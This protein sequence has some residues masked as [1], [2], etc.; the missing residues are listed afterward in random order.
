M[1]RLQRG[2][3][4]VEML[5]AIAVAGLLVSLVYGAIRVGQ[6]SVSAVDSRVQQSELMRIGWQFIHHAIAHAGPAVD[7]ARPE[8]R[9]GFEGTSDQLVFVADMPSY[10]GIEGPARITL[11]RFAKA[12]AA[13][14]LLTRGR[15]DEES[16]PRGEAELEQA[17]LVDQLDELRIEYFGQLERGVAPSWQSNWDH[18]RW[19]PN[20]IRIQIRPAGAPAWPL[21]TAAPRDGT[22]PLDEDALPA[23]TDLPGP[24]GDLAE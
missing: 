13:Q 14:L 2:F 24:T 3:T 6:R 7:P 10:V 19:L 17:V 21:L 4:V 8:T 20:L 11:G 22:A 9:T 5:V 18:A 12:G 15:L 16:T 23:E 1:R